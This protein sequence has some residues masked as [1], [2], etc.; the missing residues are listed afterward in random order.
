MPLIRRIPKRG[1]STARF[2]K[3]YQ[4]VNL[5]NLNKI[6]EDSIAPDLLKEKG[7]IKDKAKPVK[8]LGRGEIESPVTIHTHAISDKALKKIQEAGGKVEIIND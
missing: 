4:I 2:K 1:F 7:L 8:I 5:E 6:K 3:K